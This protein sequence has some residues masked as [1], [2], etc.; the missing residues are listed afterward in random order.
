MRMEIVGESRR[1]LEE[2]ILNGGITGCFGALFARPVS[3]RVALD[4][5]AEFELG[6]A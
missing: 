2:E 3:V 5:L 4:G 1:A 6:W